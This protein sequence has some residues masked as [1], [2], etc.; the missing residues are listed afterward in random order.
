MKV[1]ARV[2]RPG[3]AGDARRATGQR[4]AA[5]ASL[6]LGLRVVQMLSGLITF[7]L[8]ARSMGSSDFGI[9]TAGLAYVGL[10]STFT[11]FGL[12]NAATM[13]MASDPD[14]ESRWLGALSS[15]RAASSVVLT[16]LC[17]AG[18]PLFLQSDGDLRTVSV[19]FTSLIAI[20]GAGAVTSVFVSRLRSEIVVAILLVQTV[21][22]LAIVI[23]LNATGASAVTVAVAWVTL[24]S[25]TAVL[26]VLAARRFASLAWKGTREL[27]GP[28]FR[29]ALPMGIAGALGT[30]YYKID[31]VLV[32]EMASAHEAGIYGAA[33][34]FL[35]P[36]TF[37]PA[38]VMTSFMPVF[39]ATFADQRER[40]R[41]LVQ[42]AAEL[43]IVLGLPALLVTLVLSD[44][45][46]RNLFGTEFAGSAAVLPILM[47][48][49]L[50]ICLGTLGGYLSRV[51]GL[52]WQLPGYAAACVVVNVGMNLYLIPRHGALGAAWATAVTEVLSMVLLLGSSLRR[53]EQRLV[54][55]PFLRIGV[56]GAAMIA[57]ML[58][59]RPLGMLPALAAGGLVYAAG[60]FATRAVT[61][62]ELR[63]LRPSAGAD[64]V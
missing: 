15:L 11:E 20:N 51:V 23:V 46:V 12:T 16:V 2:L 56:A 52:R 43:M 35:D 45:I 8:L 17:L 62:A 22:W 55:L 29:L 61:M 4:I 49:F 14:N 50:A 26:Q 47:G 25:A 28:L 18:I 31:S 33:Y 32:V 60:L 27:W 3:T 48:G 54:L 9:Y 19:I 38:A 59:T 44:Q 10:F 42:T 64:A 63:Q 53:L 37:L 39:A 24:L 1:L 41:R 57:A 40:T 7:P 34:R 5:N 13:N 58:V 30:V 21:A 6:Q 36:L